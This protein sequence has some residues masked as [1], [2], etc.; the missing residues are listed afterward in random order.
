MNG[1]ER[2]RTKIYQGG[3]RQWGSGRGC[4][5]SEGAHLSRLGRLL[6]D[7]ERGLKAV[8][9]EVALDVEDLRGV[10]E[11]RDLGRRE[12]RPL[13]L[14]RRGE[15]RHERAVVA[16]DDDRARA[17]LLALLDEVALVEALARVRRLE[18]LREVVVA[19]AADVH[20]RVRREHVLG[21]G[22]WERLV[23][24]SAGAKY[25]LHDSS[26]WTH[27]RALFP[28]CWLYACYNN[29]TRADKGEF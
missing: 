12:V 3:P 15:R 9:Q 23:K 16:G 5:W 29:N 8:R 18:L 6:R 4:M 10:D 19:D 22:G 17:R 20:D 7:L 26:L 27:T 14:L 24:R 1:A 25:T 2:F 11:R 13:E 28:A 21:G